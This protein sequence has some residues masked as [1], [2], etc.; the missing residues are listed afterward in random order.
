MQAYMPRLGAWAMFVLHAYVD[1]PHVC[2]CYVHIL[3]SDSFALIINAP[4]PS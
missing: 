2:T 4:G 3:S 1:G